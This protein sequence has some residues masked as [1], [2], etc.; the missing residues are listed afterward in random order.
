MRKQ[1]EKAQA[2]IQE[3]KLSQL[4]MTPQP[5]TSPEVPAAPTLQKKPSNTTVTTL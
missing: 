2:A 1:A 5:P 4:G 3:G